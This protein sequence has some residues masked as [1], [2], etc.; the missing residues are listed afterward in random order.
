MTDILCSFNPANG[1]KLWEGACSSKE[2]IDSV[3]RLAKGAFPT[4]SLLPIGKRVEYLRAYQSLLE[5]EQKIIANAISQETG[6]PLWESTAEVAAM[7]QK[8]P[9]SIDANHA[10]CKIQEFPLNAQSLITRHRPHGILGVLGPFNFPGHLP[11]GHIIP[12]LL[13]GNSVIFKPSELT[14][15]VGALI[16]DLFERVGLP[17]GVFSLIQG[18]ADVGHILATHE[19]LSGLLFTGSAQTGQKLAASFGHHPEKILALE[20]GGNNPLV[21]NDI[22]NI[23]ATIY[24]TIQSA[25]LTSGQRC[26]SARRLI[27]IEDEQTEAFLERLVDWTKQIHIGPFTDDPEPFMGPLI[28]KEAADHL[29]SKQKKLLA[30]GGIPL[31]EMKRLEKGD[32]WVSP[33]ILD[34]TSIPPDDE[35]LFGPLLKVIRTKTLKEA[36]SIANDT[37]YGLSAGIVTSDPKLYDTFYNNVQAGIINWNSPLTGASSKAPFGGV[38]QSGNHRPS[39]WYAADYSAYP[40]ASLESPKIILPE[41]LSPGL[42]GVI[43]ELPRP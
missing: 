10:R 1:E 41:T 23:E 37:S 21:I 31:L 9:I 20:M 7:I 8:I 3:F 5:Q 26:T 14:P 35:E 36:I 6:K 16:A 34:V 4:W 25:F 11:N 38:G 30:K 42:E 28:S 43:H 32:A 15:M 24:L 29:L 17:N 2:E 33:G 13:A 22:S 39:A 40:V 12:A 27:I 18:K 19:E